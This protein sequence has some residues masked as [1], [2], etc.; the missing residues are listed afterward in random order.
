MSDT[1]F[2][3]VVLAAGRSTRTVTFNKLTAP[4]GGKPMVFYAIRHLK[5]ASAREIIAV[6]GHDRVKVMQS[7]GGGVT[8]AIQEHQLG[9]GHAAAQALPFVADAEH[10]AVLFGDCPFLDSQIIRAT[11]ERHLATGAMLTVTTSRV[12]NASAW[13]RVRREAGQIQSVVDGRR[14]PSGEDETE[15][16]AGL[17]IWTAAAFKTLVPELPL[18]ELP[19]GS[20]EHNLPDAVQLA[21]DRGMR[22]ECFSAVDPHDA[23]APNNPLEFQL[24]SDYIRIK[25]SEHLLDNDVEFEDLQSVTID[26]DVCVAR[27]SRLGRN[28]RLLGTTTVG[29]NCRIGPDSTL[30]NCKIDSGATIGRGTWEGV[31]FPPGAVA[32][33][34]LAGKQLYFSTPHYHI[35]EEPGLCFGILPFSHPYPAL[36]DNVIWPIVQQHGFHYEIADRGR[37]GVVADH[38]WEGINRASLI[39][40]EISEDNP[41]VWFECGLAHAMNK[42]VVMFRRKDRP[43]PFDV[44][45]LRVIRYDPMA[46]DAAPQLNKWFLELERTRRRD[47]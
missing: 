12:R 31:Y 19:G 26:Y 2:V 33:D 21:N 47:G 27:G 45:H 1:K 35:P 38:I 24:A 40:A 22:V 8:W 43:I 7:I 4:I 32:S 46:G 9:T 15:V 10:V 41:N 25:K 6:I 17:S 28:V 16:F 36:F 42:Q 11:I 3:G 39:L 29:E 5:D 13:G 18:I 23:I 20:A 34:R 44:G 37:L 14:E 30:Q